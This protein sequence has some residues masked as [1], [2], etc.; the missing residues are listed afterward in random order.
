MTGTAPRR[1]MPLH[2]QRDGFDPV[3]QL[4]DFEHGPVLATT[5][6]GTPARIVN[7]YAAVREVLANA[8]RF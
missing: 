6:L 8:E 4:T 5:S 7:R 1:P 3:P 2:L